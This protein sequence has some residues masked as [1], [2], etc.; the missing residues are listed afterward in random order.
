M[1][2]RWRLVVFGAV[3]L[4]AAGNGYLARPEDELAGIKRFHPKTHWAKGFGD[5]PT[6]TWFVFEE[7]APVMA[8]FLPG[9]RL[10]S[11][12]D[13]GID[14]WTEVTDIELS[15]GRTARLLDYHNV[16]SMNRRCT[17]IVGDDLRPWYAKA[18]SAIKRRLRL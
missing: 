12:N 1:K 11:R 8:Q 14:T 15:S 4:L 6:G 3:C 17:L 9:R 13:G 7:S 5:I 16:F 18:W 2:F 10:G